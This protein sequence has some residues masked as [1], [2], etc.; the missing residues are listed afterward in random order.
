MTPWI[1]HQTAVFCSTVQ[2]GTSVVNIFHGRANAHPYKMRLWPSNM[3]FRVKSYPR[4][5]P[6]RKLP[7][8]PIIFGENHCCASNTSCGT[9][10]NQ[11]RSNPSSGNRR[12]DVHGTLVLASLSITLEV[13]DLELRGKFNESTNQQHSLLILWKTKMIY[14]NY[15]NV[16]KKMF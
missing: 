16:E 9:D 14:L 8:L 15:L 10:G 11:T 6:N 3:L 5:R 4:K 1:I 7:K 13:L 12:S 2:Q